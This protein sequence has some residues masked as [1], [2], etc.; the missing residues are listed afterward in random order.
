MQDTSIA[1]KEQVDYV[2]FYNGGCK[3]DANVSLHK[4]ADG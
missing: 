2:K 4:H 1:C 3:N